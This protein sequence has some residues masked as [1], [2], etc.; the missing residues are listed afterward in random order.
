MTRQDVNLDHLQFPNLSQAV[1]SGPLIALSGQVGLG[2]DGDVVPGGAAAQAEQAFRNIDAVL[3]RAGAG[4]EHVVR[5]TC[6]L[7]SAEHYGA[8]NAAKQ[9]WLGEHAP[10]GT[11][12]VVAA[13]LEPRLVLEVEVL[14]YVEPEDAPQ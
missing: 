4:P 7:T 1:R 5:L 8:Y 9:A 3:A 14:A 11:V 2:A 13:L 10:A 6:Y 12:V